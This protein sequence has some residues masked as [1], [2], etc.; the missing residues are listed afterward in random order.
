VIEIPLSQGLVALIDDEDF[1]AVD[2]HGKWHAYRC[3][4][5][6]YARKNYNR[7]GTWVSLRMHQ[8]ITGWDF[9]DHING[10]GLDNRRV[11][12]RPATVALNARNRRI[13]SNNTSGYK[14][15]YRKENRWYATVTVDGRHY[16]LGGYATAEEA[17]RAYDAG[18]L[19]HHGEFARLNFPKD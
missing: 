7:G 10:D 17:A 19:I 1:D 9:V 5:T 2:A 4:C 16:A 13:R 12:L 15:I 3:R 6:F 14:G 11:N 18:A 8:V